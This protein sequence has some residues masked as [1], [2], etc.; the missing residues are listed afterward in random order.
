MYEPMSDPVSQLSEHELAELAAL[1]DGTLAADRRSEV[2]ARVAESP[3]LKELLERQRQSLAL[4]AALDDEPSASLQAA[5][6]GRVRT[7]TAR[8]RSLAPRLAA[9]GVAVAAVAV[10]A[11]VLTGGPGA[12]SV[13]QAAELAAKSPTAPAPASVDGSKLAADVEGVAFPDYAQ[14]FGWRALGA[15]NGRVGGRDATVV[16]YGKDN[17]RIAY[18]IVSGDGLP[19]P[20]GGH[21]TTIGGIQYQAVFLNGRIVVTWQRAG[22]TCVLIG[23]ASD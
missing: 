18:A 13:A 12:P 16:H 11:V 14:P 15:R 19:S 8:R 6:R 7:P 10:A 2:E 21:T 23:D 1:A 5:V 22:R 17:R 4:T 9:L 3:E 20:S